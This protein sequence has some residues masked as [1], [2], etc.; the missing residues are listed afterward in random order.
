MWSILEHFE[1][2]EFFIFFWIIRTHLSKGWLTLSKGWLT[3]IQETDVW[4]YINLILHQKQFW[5]PKYKVSFCFQKSRK[6]VACFQNVSKYEESCSPRVPSTKLLLFF[7]SDIMLLYNKMST[8]WRR[9]IST[10]MYYAYCII[11]YKYLT[12]FMSF[13]SL[14]CTSSIDSISIAAQLV[15]NFSRTI[16]SAFLAFVNIVW[17]KGFLMKHNLPTLIWHMCRINTGRV[18]RSKSFSQ[19]TLHYLR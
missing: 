8:T 11:V 13:L 6:K 4:W 12:V 17:S 3:I 7:H 9:L 2:I 18:I 10:V 16:L 15:S 19:T 5:R 1:K 14:F